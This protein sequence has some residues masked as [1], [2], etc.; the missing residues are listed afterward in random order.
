MSSNREG[1]AGDL[2]QKIGTSRA[3]TTAAALKNEHS[4]AIV[5]KN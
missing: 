3:Q 2:M 5:F 4:F 1:S